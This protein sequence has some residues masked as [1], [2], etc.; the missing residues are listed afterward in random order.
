MIVTC[1]HCGNN[2]DVEMGHD[3]WICPLCFGFI[4][5]KPRRS[6]E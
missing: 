4:Q 5:Q 3:S 6:E 1:P 2:V